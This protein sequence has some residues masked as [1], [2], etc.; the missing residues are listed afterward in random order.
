MNRSW[1]YERRLLQIHVSCV[2]KQPESFAASSVLYCVQGNVINWAVKGSDS[3][4]Q[5]S[6]PSL[7]WQKQ[8]CTLMDSFLVIGSIR[9]RISQCFNCR[10]SITTLQQRCLWKLVF[11]KKKSPGA[12]FGISSHFIAI[13]F[14]RCPTSKKTLIGDGFWSR[15]EVSVTN[16]HM[17]VSLRLRGHSIK[18]L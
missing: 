9:R 7:D 4:E 5:L 10:C 11:K 14:L 17:L 2:L 8:V 12:S 3:W 16:T 15:A 1:E 6:E 18:G 13:S